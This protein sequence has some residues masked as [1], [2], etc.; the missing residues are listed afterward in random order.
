MTTKLPFYKTYES[1][2]LD[3]DLLLDLD[4]F[5]VQH[6]HFFDAYH[7]VLT[8]IQIGNKDKIL[9]VQAPTGT[10]KTTLREKVH[11]SVQ[12]WASE[13]LKREPPITVSVLPP[14]GST[15]SFRAFYMQLL[16][17]MNEPLPDEK[18]NPERRREVLQK[19]HFTPNLKSTGDIRLYL[20]KVLRERPPSAILLDEAQHL[21]RS[22]GRK[23]RI[24]HLDVAKS[25]ADVSSSKVVMFGTPE[26]SRLLDL[27]S[28][29]SR[30]VKPIR[31]EL[32][33][34]T[35]GDLKKYYKSYLT[36]CKGLKI[37][38]DVGA[39]NLSYLYRRTMGSVGLLSEW[40]REAGEE[41]LIIGD[42]TIERRH[43]DLTGPKKATLSLMKA[44]MKLYFDQRPDSENDKPRKS[45]HAKKG[46]KRATR[47]GQRNRNKR[48]KAGVSS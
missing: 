1:R 48:D 2:Q 25:I 18:L 16:E 38:I 7:R 11:H 5:V 21:G 45:K 23:Q 10:G 42:K 44:E 34:N 4:N 12:R 47:V 35:E 22:A 28:Q 8:H 17:A 40:I 41:A 33:K 37:P 46:K 20:D 32:Y 31:F 27:N 13:D 43:L 36:L 3:G 39:E 24:D 6:P 19:D 29:L 26:S 9:L 15:F 30:R 14:E